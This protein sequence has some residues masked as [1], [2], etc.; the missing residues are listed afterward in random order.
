MNTPTINTAPPTEARATINARSEAAEQTHYWRVVA[1]GR[2]MTLVTLSVAFREPEDDS[3]IVRSPAF[4]QDV[5]DYL[6]EPAAR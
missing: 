2:L 4:E 6:D 1:N 5:L 3:D